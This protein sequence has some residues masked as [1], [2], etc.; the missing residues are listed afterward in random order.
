MRTLLLT[1]SIAV[2][3]FGCDP[4]N[5]NQ[6]TSTAYTKKG[7]VVAHAGGYEARITEALKK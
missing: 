6:A 7:I 3:S 1:I 5:S 2:P 4:S